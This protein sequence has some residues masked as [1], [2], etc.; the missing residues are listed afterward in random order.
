MTANCGNCRLWGM[1]L[2]TRIPEGVR[3][4]NCCADAVMDLPASWN[5]STPMQA[6][7]GA[8]C[9]IWEPQP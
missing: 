5:A 4:G 2:H 7:D 8:N 6:T 9:P 3:P 1:N